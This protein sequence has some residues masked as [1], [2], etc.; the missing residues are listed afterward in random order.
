MSEE[1]AVNSVFKMEKVD[2]DEYI[3]QLAQKT[4]AP[5]SICFQDPTRT[6][7]SKRN[8]GS[9]V[10]NTTKIGFNYSKETEAMTISSM[11]ITLQ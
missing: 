4:H 9:F 2:K 1:K 8:A 11:V 6:I 10:D 5:K 7:N 3:L